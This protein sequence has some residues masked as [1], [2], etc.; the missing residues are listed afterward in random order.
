MQANSRPA[1]ADPAGPESDPLP[2]LAD[3]RPK[4]RKRTLLGGLVS[5]SDGA[6]CFDCRI[7]D[8]SDSGARITFPA[9]RPAPNIVYLINI[10]D[11]VAYEATIVW[12]KGA[13]GGLKFLRT[14]AVS[15]PTESNLGYLKKLWCSRALR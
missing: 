5:F 2:P 10:R 11:A 15:D 4:T 8:L 13:E 14:F 1:F 9:D 12:R 6:E 3:R 7:K